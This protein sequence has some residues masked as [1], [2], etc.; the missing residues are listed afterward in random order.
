[1]IDFDHT[2]CSDLAQA[3]HREWLETNGL[4][5]FASSTITCL[6]TRRYHGLLVAATTPPAGRTSLL[7]KLEET[8]IV[9]DSRFELSCNKYPGVVHPQGYNYLMRFRLDPFP[10]FTYEV[11]G[12]QIEKAVFMVYGENTTVVEHR[13]EGGLP[14][15]QDCKLELRPLISFRDHHWTTHENPVFNREVKISIGQASITPYPGLPTLYLAHNAAA[16]ETNGDWY[17]R[18]QYDDEA[19]A[20]ALHWIIGLEQ[21]VSTAGLGQVSEIFDGDAPHTPRGCISQAWSVAELL[22][23]AAEL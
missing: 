10:L 7:S 23:V 11:E 12:L 19:R 5:G 6:N 18:F 9:D 22:R 2:I 16:V 13:L 4:G 1:M 8:L 21:R 17:R 3:N 20:Q 14:S 15:G